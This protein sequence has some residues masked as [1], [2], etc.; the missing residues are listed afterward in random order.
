MERAANLELSSIE[1]K[2][3]VALKRIRTNGFF[4]GITVRLATASLSTARLRTR[5]QYN[6]FQL[7]LYAN[8]IAAVL[9]SCAVV[10][11]PV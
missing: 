6:C 4:F 7:N 3:T 9:H 5:A 2:K 8:H 1:K 11:V 10:L